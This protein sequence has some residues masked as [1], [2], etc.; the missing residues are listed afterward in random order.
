MK[1]LL[2]TNNPHK[3][4][5]VR[6]IIGS[7][8]IE[9]VCGSDLGIHVD[10]EENG[11]TF[12]ENALAKAEAFALAT[13][14]PTIADDSGLL[15]DALDG[16]PGIHTARYA[17]EHGGFPAVFDYL[18]A[19]LNGKNKTARFHCCICYLSSP[20]AKPR[21]FEADCPGY[22]LDQPVGNGGFGYDP[23]FHASEPNVDFGIADPE[24]KN[25]YSHRG[26]AV[27]KLI[28]FLKNA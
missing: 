4:E 8:D 14:L 13:G 9:I 2:A 23:I 27:A 12:R 20:N 16:N 28:S 21:F 24:I 10:P 5:E 25:R 11:T 1:L 26:K 17:E 7:E 22:L 6:S 18:R 15:I 19:V 3:A